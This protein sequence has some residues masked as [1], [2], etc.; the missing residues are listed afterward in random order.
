MECLCFQNAQFK[1]LS[2]MQ[3]Q[4][5]LREFLVQN[6]LS[7]AT[8]VFQEC[9]YGLHAHPH[10]NNENLGRSWHFG[11]V[12]VWSTWWGG[13]GWCVETN[14]SIPQGYRLVHTCKG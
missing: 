3:Q 13:G 14:H 2:A 1:L 9:W 7:A 11:F 10:P 4:A 12:L 8:Q 5:R 6:S